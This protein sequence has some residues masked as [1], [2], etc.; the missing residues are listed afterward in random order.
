MPRR[1]NADTEA[2]HC[3]IC[4]RRVLVERPASGNQGFCPQC[5]TPL[6]I[7]STK[8]DTDLI[9]LVH[10]KAVEPL[11]FDAEEW[12]T[13]SMRLRG[14]MAA[15]LISTRR[16][17]KLSRTE[18]VQLLGRPGGKTED[19]LWYGV[20]LGRREDFRG[21]AYRLRITF[22]GKGQAAAVELEGHQLRQDS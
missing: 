4:R 10:G 19:T 14:N 2:V 18:V 15:D 3:R 9:I 7:T 11:P 13:A 8:E 22:D 17:M 16:L 20:D 21:E 12:S 6:W 1:S 5:G